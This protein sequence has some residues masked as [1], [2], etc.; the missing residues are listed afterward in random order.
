[1]GEAMKAK[2]PAGRFARPDEIAALILYLVSDAAA[3]VNGENIVID[4]GYTAQ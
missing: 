4:G 3:M 2:I 1:V